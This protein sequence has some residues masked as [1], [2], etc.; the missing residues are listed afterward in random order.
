MRK[1]YFGLRVLAL[2]KR[3]VVAIESI[4]ESQRAIA[5]TVVA[6]TRPKKAPKFAEVHVPTIAEQNAAWQRQ[7]DA[8]IYGEELP[9]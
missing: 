4:A 2:I 5:E 7:R 8:E 6:P 3:A 9:E 1:F